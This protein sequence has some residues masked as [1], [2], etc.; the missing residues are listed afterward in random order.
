MYG[1][2]SAI[3]AVVRTAEKQAFMLLQSVVT[4]SISKLNINF[5]IKWPPP[6]KYGN[7]CQKANIKESF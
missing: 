4:T 5:P 2:D 7:N 3:N 6:N 1:L